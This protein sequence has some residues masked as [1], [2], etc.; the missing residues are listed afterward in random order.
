MYRHVTSI[1]LY[2]LLEAF[3]R[4]T[5]SRGRDKHKGKEKKENRRNTISIK[6]DKAT[7]I[8]EADHVVS[9]DMHEDKIE[10]RVVG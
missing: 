8:G 9:R 6:Y 10:V 5:S 7:Q 3:Y 1:L 4:N 2:V